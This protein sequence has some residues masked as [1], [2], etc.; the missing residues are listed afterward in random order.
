MNSIQILNLFKA[1]EEVYHWQ[2][3]ILRYNGCSYTTDG[4]SACKVK[5]IVLFENKFNVSEINLQILDNHFEKWTRLGTLEIKKLN[6][7]DLKERKYIGINDYIFDTMLLK[8]LVKI[9]LDCEVYDS[10]IS[11]NL[12]I[13][14]YKDF[15][16]ILFKTLGKEGSLNF[17]LK[18]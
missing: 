6:T 18:K 2:T 7:K 4:I 10:K 14:D 8:R 15:E 11:S 1:I 17:M 16:V 12:L 5:E 3:E 13:F 9:N